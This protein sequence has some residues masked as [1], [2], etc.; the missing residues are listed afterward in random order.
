MSAPNEPPP[1]HRPEDFLELV[2]RGR[3]G[4]LKLYVGFAAGVGKTYRMLQEAHALRAKGGDVVIGFVETHGRAET[5]ALVAGLEVVPRRRVEYRGLGIEEMDV[6]AILRRAPEVCI[7]DEIPHTNVP[8]SR[9][10]RRFEDVQD[11]LDAGIHVVGAMNVQHVESLVDLVHR[12][13]GVEVRET[14]PDTFLRQA[15]QIVNVDLSVEDLVERLRAGKVYAPAKVDLALGSFF[16]PDNLGALREMALR[17][18]AETL[19]RSSSARGSAPG[20]APTTPVSGRV[21]VCLASASPRAALMLRRAARIAGRLNTDWF[22]VH[23]E[24]PSESPMR[25][26]AEAQRKL[27]RSVELARELGAEIAV[28]RSRDPV[29]AVVDFARSHGVAHVIVGRSGQKGWRRVL[30]RTFVDRLLDEAHDLDVHVV[31]AE[32]AEDGQDAARRDATD[33][34]G[35]SPAAPP[36]GPRGGGHA[37]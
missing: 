30:R 22:A 7:V 35:P 20:A 5:E 3:R 16:R 25:I 11:L 37:P 1:R 18:V 28:V 36:P 8:G 14:V 29:T 27:I 9:N 12:V 34:D 15:D 10:T 23:V 26:D 32:L 2:R 21:L 24:T 17:E 33:A 19:G 31:A 6:D 13:T 4:R